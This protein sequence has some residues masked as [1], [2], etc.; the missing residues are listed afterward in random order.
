MRLLA[1][2]WMLCL[3]LSGGVSPES[4]HEEE[5]TLRE[6]GRVSTPNSRKKELIRTAPEPHPPPAAARPS[7]EAPERPRVTAWASRLHQRSPTN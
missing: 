1:W 6:R 4:I 7:F 5:E 2:S 3:G